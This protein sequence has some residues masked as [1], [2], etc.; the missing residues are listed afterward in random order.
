[1]FVQFQE[2]TPFL[3]R[4]DVCP[5]SRTDPFSFRETS[6][7]RLNVFFELVDESGNRIEA[8][9][10]FQSETLP[11]DLA[12]KT[13]ERI[14]TGVL[15]DALVNQAKAVKAGLLATQEARIDQNTY[16]VI[17]YKPDMRA[18]I[19]VAI[20]KDAQ[21]ESVRRALITLM[22]ATIGVEEVKLVQEVPDYATAET[23]R[24]KNL[25]VKAL[26][27]LSQKLYQAYVTLRAAG[28]AA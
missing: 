11:Q 23:Y 15:S 6:S 26:A 7:N 9:Q 12:G 20:A 3:S 10:G 1:M 25:F 27:T 2:L 14:Y 5:I 22:Q 17:P 18:G 8:L 21:D 24:Q 28:T 19:M 4:S 16:N 13:V